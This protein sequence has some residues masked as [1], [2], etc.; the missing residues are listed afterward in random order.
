MNIRQALISIGSAI[1]LVPPATGLTL[2]MSPIYPEYAVENCIE[3]YVRVEITYASDGVV[4]EIQILEASPEGVF[5][6]ATRKNLRRWQK[7]EKAGEVE[8]TTIE[9]TLDSTEHCNS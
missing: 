8:E 9:Y 2:T 6:D 1:F 3:G 4:D 5:E 7:P